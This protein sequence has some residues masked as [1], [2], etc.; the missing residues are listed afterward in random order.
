MFFLVAFRRSD[1]RSSDLFPILLIE[2]IL[3]FFALWSIQ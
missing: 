2:N 3:I 1:F